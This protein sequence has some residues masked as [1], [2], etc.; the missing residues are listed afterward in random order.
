MSPGGH[1]EVG[2]LLEALGGDDVPEQVDDLFAL[3]GDLHLHHGVVEQVAPV[4]GR[5]RADVVDGPQGEEPHGHQARVG[6]DEELFDLRELGHGF[7]EKDAVRGVVD[8]LVE[9]VGADPDGGP[10]QVELAHVDRV[11][12]GIPGLLPLLEDLLFLDRVVVQVVLGHV[13]LARHDVSHQLEL[14]VVRIDGEEDVLARTGDLAEGGDDDGLVGV[15][16]VVLV[17][18]GQV[19]AAA[20]GLEHHVGRI[21]V[22]AVL[23]LGEAEG[24]DPAVL[25]VL[26]GL[27][28]YLLVLAHPDGAE[29]QDRDLPGVPVGQAVEG[30]GSR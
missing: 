21:D 5:G 14:F 9:G 17:A 7:P 26:G 28:L 18:L 25:Q 24:E 30:R 13:L 22:G 20:L 27:L 3:H 23:P 1:L 19:G 8:G 29:A 11:E 4:F 6:I 16:D 2:V 10:A 15:A 12:R